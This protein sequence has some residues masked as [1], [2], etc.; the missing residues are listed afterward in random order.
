MD[1]KLYNGDCLVS[2]H[3]PV[4]VRHEPYDNQHNSYTF[5]F[6]HLWR[7]DLPTW[8]AELMTTKFQF[9]HLWRCDVDLAE[10]SQSAILFQFTHLWRCDFRPCQAACSDSCFNAR[11]CEGATPRWH[12]GFQWGRVSI[13]APVKVRQKA[14]YAVT[15]G[16]K[17]QFTHLWRCDFFFQGLRV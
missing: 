3:A 16:S 4:K 13:H 17:F 12:A 15:Y 1:I 7:C 2:I 8:S 14:P 10:I 5:Q 9:T 11:T 6:T